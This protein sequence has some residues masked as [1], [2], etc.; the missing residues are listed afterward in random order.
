MI[1]IARRLVACICLYRTSL[2]L[3]WIRTWLTAFYGAIVIGVR[4][5]K[6]Y[7]VHTLHNRLVVDRIRYWHAA[8]GM[9]ALNAGTHAVGSLGVYYHISHTYD[10]F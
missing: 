1:L 10:Y 8:N 3:H 5:L 6:Y 4:T 7:G 2:D 9:L